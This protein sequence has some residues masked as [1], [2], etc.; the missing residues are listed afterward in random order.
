MQSLRL[1]IIAALALIVTPGPDIIYVLS[2][3]ITDGRSGGLV[4]ALG[5]TCGICIHT[6]AASLGLAV[7][8][9]TSVIG[10]WILKL[11]GGMHIELAL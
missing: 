2:R 3:G 8:L 9:Q 5:V 10:F 4:S 7:L 11:A 6:L 1:Y